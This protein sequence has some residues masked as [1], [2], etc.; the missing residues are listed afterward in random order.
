MA[1]VADLGEQLSK[2]IWPICGS[3]RLLFLEARAGKEA[4]DGLAR[5][6]SG[7]P[8]FSNMQGPL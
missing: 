2:Y 7:G 4:K 6:P 3:W 5:L 1:S 8:N